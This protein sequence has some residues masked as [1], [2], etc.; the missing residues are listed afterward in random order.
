MCS[1]AKSV[2]IMSIRNVEMWKDH[3]WSK[4]HQKCTKRK[5]NMLHALSNDTVGV[6]DSVCFV[7][8]KRNPINYNGKNNFGKN[9]IVFGN[10]KADFIGPCVPVN[11]SE[12]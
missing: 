8:L 6:L 11:K 12:S 4:A 7:F 9:K 5:K 2:N 1:I 3:L 10:S